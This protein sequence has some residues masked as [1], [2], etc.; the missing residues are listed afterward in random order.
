MEEAPPTTQYIPEE[1]PNPGGWF[2]GA[3]VGYLDEFDEEMYHVHLGAATP[4]TFSGWNLAWFIEAGWT[5]SDD[6][7]LADDTT[8][9]L[10]YDN[11]ELEIIPVTFN[12][13]L[14]RTLGGNFG[15]YFGAGAGVGFIDYEADFFAGGGV[16]E[17]DEVFAAQAFAGVV[18]NVSEQFEI[19]AGGRWIYLDYDTPTNLG[20]AELD[21]GND[22]FLG[23]IGMRI[24]F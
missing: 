12:L 5:E 18:Y 16:D 2:A 10:G 15:V 9:P 23:E 4:T 20:I 11:Q 17:E 3:S 6:R 1:A 7:S 8:I 13:K 21:F 19:F 22:D 24:N 14:E